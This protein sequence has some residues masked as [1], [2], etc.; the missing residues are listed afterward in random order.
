MVIS[1]IMIN[2]QHGSGSVDVGDWAANQYLSLQK[3]HVIHVQIK[4]LAVGLRIAEALKQNNPVH[5]YV[6]TSQCVY[7][8]IILRSNSDHA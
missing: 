7:I 8:E 2:W 5:P 4:T 1:N 3:P 6:R